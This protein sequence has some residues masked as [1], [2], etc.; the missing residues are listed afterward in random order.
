MPKLDQC[1]EQVVRALQ[2]DGWTV[3]AKP[4][5]VRTDT[6]KIFIDAGASRKVNG[7]IQ[8]IML[9]EI[10]CFPDR[11]STTEELYIAIGQYIV[12]R[13]V[14]QDRQIDIPLYLAVPEDV[15]KDVF[16]STIQRGMS[17]NKIKAIIVDLSTETISEW[18]E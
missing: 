6:R 1:H 3:G 17:D 9:I 2:K 14:L 12:Y 16:D 10:K 11:D 13:A 7:S 18:K 8:Q 4:V 5:T 15:Y